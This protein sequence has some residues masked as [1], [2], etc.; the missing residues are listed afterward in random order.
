[1]RQVGLTEKFRSQNQR[2]DHVDETVHRSV[3]NRLTQTLGNTRGDLNS[4]SDKWF[5]L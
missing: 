3:N 2:S 1:M 4:S 5:K